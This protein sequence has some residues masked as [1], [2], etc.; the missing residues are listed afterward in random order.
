MVDLSV[1]LAGLHLRNPLILGAGPPGS[2]GELLKKMAR[3]GAGAVVTKSIGVVPQKY[4]PRPRMFKIGNSLISTDPWSE[5]HYKEWF[6]KEI[7]IAKEGGVPII[8]SLQSMSEDPKED[9]EVLIPAAEEAGVDAIELSAFGSSPNT[10]KGIGIGPIQSPDRTK[11]VVKAAKKLTGLPVIAKFIPEIWN[12]LDLIKAAEDGGADAIAL[13]DTVCPAIRYNI[14]TGMPIVNRV[15]SKW[16]AELSGPAIL[17]VSLGYVTE[18]YR[19]TKLPIIGLGG[20]SNWESAVEMILAGATCVGICTAAIIY[21]PGIFKKITEGMEKYMEK[22]GYQTI[23]EFK[24]LGVRMLEREWSRE[25]VLPL[26]SSVD[27]DTCTG[28]GI[29][30]KGCLYD[31]IRIENGKAIVDKEKCVG[32]GVCV[33]VCPVKAIKLVE[34]K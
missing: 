1:E 30:L 2:S 3:G 28:C 25:E 8:A 4:V 29:C 32:C 9:L 18:A 19:N 6:E 21:G 13:R 22:K 26:V 15:K 7:K 31:A 20:V 12:F 5:K 16:L 17:A 10:F 14:E 33:S 27:V 34:K 11:E 23:Q 24:G